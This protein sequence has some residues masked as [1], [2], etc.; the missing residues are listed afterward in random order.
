MIMLARSLLAILIWV[1]SPCVQAQSSTYPPI[2]L[3]G[4]GFEV[5][6]IGRSG[7]SVKIITITN[8]PPSPK[9]PNGSSVADYLMVDC[10][11]KRASTVGRGANA[12]RQTV[13]TVEP[14]GSICYSKP[15]ARGTIT[16][17]VTQ[18]QI[19]Q[20]VQRSG[21][22]AGRNGDYTRRNEADEEVVAVCR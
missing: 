6:I 15:N 1:S 12:V 22:Y 11:T 18:E 3:V 10:S 5:K 4:M 21:G 2:S 7:N 20:R 8:L 13:V 9:E 16:C 17:E 19:K 14:L